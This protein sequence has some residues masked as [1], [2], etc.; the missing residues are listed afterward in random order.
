MDWW[1]RNRFTKRHLQYLQARLKINPGSFG[2]DTTFAATQIN[3]YTNTDWYKMLNA[4]RGLNDVCRK[5]SESTP[6][7]LGGVVESAKISC[8]THLKEFGKYVDENGVIRQGQPNY[9][10]RVN[11]CATLRWRL[12]EVKDYL[13]DAIAVMEDDINIRRQFSKLEKLF[14]SGNPTDR[15][16][17]VFA[18]RLIFTSKENDL[19]IGRVLRVMLNKV[20]RDRATEYRINRPL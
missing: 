9:A 12:H 13:S 4:C 10:R 8:S 6:E 17:F 16:A 20:I 3:M 19:H 14:K 5:L 11:S 7:N 2:D 1:D 18:K 15:N